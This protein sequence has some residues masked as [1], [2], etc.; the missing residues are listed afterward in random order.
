MLRAPLSLKR[1]HKMEDGRILIELKRRMYD[2]T[3][4]IALT[5]RHLLRRLA[6]I[7]PPPRVHSTRYF[8]AFAPSSKVRPKIIAPH[9]AGESKHDCR[10]HGVIDE[11]GCGDAA[12]AQA[13]WTEV[14]QDEDF[15][16]PPFPDRPRRLPWADLLKR[17]FG[18]DVLVCGKCGGKR[19]LTAFMP[20][21]REASEILERLGI[22][23]T[24]PP[25]APARA[26][27]HQEEFALAP[28][29]YGIDP[30]SPDLP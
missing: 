4:A 15:E 6:S 13:L 21:P 12:I 1:M 30:P 18:Q 29:E 5:P 8:G 22:D 17:V 2:G 27:P 16:G 14:A 3:R 26:P 20:D 23:A 9:K 10:E 19:K 24:A 25:V 28:V 7:V 11:G